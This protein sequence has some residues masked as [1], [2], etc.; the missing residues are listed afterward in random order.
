MSA[1]L[2]A[3]I[4]LLSIPECV[5]C[6]NSGLSPVEVGLEESVRPQMTWRDTRVP[7]ASAEDRM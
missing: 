5:A 4:K 3:Y 7:F 1:G 2:E 6:I